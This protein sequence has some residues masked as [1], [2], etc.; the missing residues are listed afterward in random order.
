MGVSTPRRKLSLQRPSGWN[1]LDGLEEQWEGWCDW[2]VASKGEGWGDEWR[3]SQG[4]RMWDFLGHDKEADFQSR[5]KLGE[6]F[7]QEN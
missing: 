1:K 6:H 7:R 5:W 4:P 3:H 2:S